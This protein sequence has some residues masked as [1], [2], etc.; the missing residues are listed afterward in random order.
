MLGAWGVSRSS[1]RLGVWKRRLLGAV[2]LGTGT[3]PLP[4]GLTSPRPAWGQISETLPEVSVSAPRPKPRPPRRAEPTPRRAASSAPATR[5]HAQSPFQFVA[6]TPITGLGFDRSKVPAMVQTLPAE[7]FSR[8]YSPNVVETSCS[9]FLASPPTTS[10]ATSSPRTYA[11]AASRLRRYRARRRGSPSTCKASAS[12]KPSETPSTGDSEGRDRPLGYL[13]QQSGLRPQRPWWRDQLP[14]E[15]R[16]YLQRHRVRCLRRLLRPRRR[17]PAIR[18]A[19]RRMGALSRRGRPQG[20]RLAL[21][22]AIAAC[23]LLRRSRLEGHRCRDPSGH[24][25]SRQFLRRDRTDADRTARQR[26]SRDLHL[27]ADHQERSGAG[28]AQR[29]LLRNRPL[30]CPKQSLLSPV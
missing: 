28:R 7:D 13:D 25:R 10:R 6:P 3:L 4:G 24:V 19:Q 29:P 11:I 17:V 30:D 1:S 15:G 23:A 8:V 16:L 27:A 20:R 21:P 26:L 14:D 12:M 5:E 9:A 22:V 18:S 2:A